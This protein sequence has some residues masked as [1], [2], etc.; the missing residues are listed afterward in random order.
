MQNFERG[1]RRGLNTGAARTT[2]LRHDTSSSLFTRTSS[3]GKGGGRGAGVL[4][5]LAVQKR[6]P[7]RPNYSLQLICFLYRAC[8]GVSASARGCGARPPPRPEDRFTREEV[9]DNGAARRC[10]PPSRELI[11]G[12]PAPDGGDAARSRM[13]ISH[14][15]LTFGAGGEKVAYGFDSAWRKLGP[16]ARVRYTQKRIVPEATR[17]ALH[18]PERSTRMQARRGWRKGVFRCP[19]LARAAAALCDAIHRRAVVQKV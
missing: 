17:V 2:S 9:T 16:L 3:G 8:C 19:N 10:A 11:Y 5:H 4:T 18:T 14:R 13:S 7:L 6:L 1:A 15:Q 12:L